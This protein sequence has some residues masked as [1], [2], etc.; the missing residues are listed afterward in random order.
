MPSA[1]WGHCKGC[2]MW[3]IEPE[4]EIAEETMGLCVAE[5]LQQYRLLVSGASGCNIYVH[6]EVLRAEGSGEA[7]PVAAPAK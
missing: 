5:D 6:G 4:A 2:K 7:P 3:Q 1:N